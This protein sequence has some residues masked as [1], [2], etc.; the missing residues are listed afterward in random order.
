[1]LLR[2]ALL[3]ATILAVPAVAFAQPVEGLYVGGGVGVNYLNSVKGKNIVIANPPGTVSASRNIVNANFSGAAGFIGLASVG[4]GL[5][6][7]LRFELEGNYRQT[8][9]SLQ[10][11]SGNNFTRLGGGA[12]F[13]QYGAM[14]NAL[15]DFDLGTGWIYPISAL[16]S[17]MRT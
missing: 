3:T 17:A 9:N 4:Y 1:M 6:N 15:Y 12:Q 10:N 5:G 14:V 13:N 11:N 16:A 2:R 7:G 8:T